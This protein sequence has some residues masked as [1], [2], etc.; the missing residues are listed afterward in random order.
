MPDDA[1][2]H[3]HFAIYP[4]HTSLLLS[5]EPRVDKRHH[6]A[7]NRVMWFNELDKTHT[8]SLANLRCQV[9]CFAIM[10]PLTHGRDGNAATVSPLLATYLAA[11]HEG[12]RSP[13]IFTAREDF[14]AKWQATPGD[15]FTV[16]KKILRNIKR[17]MSEADRKR[18]FHTQ[19]PTSAGGIDDDDDSSGDEKS[20]QAAGP[21]D[22]EMKD[23][24]S[25]EG[26]DEDEPA[27]GTAGK[28]MDDLAEVMGD[29]SSLG[30]SSQPLPSIHYEFEALMQQPEYATRTEEQKEQARLD[31]REIVYQDMMKEI[32]EYEASDKDQDDYGSRIQILDEGLATLTE[33]IYESDLWA[34]AG[35]SLK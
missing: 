17:S 24:T 16:S 28:E 29:L 2:L 8:F 19:D 21:E 27:A 3:H 23:A 1:R 25:A 12:V 32:E 26:D 15:I 34:L 30:P 31:Y 14:I 18:V 4:E 22:T 6:P 10:Q 11:S 5:S 13:G 7:L 33:S 20:Y 35:L 9:S